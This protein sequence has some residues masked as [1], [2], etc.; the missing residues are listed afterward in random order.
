MVAAG[1]DTW[2]LNRIDPAGLPLALRHELDDL[3]QRAAEDEEEVDTRW[4]YDGAPLR[5]YRAGVN[6]EKGGGVSW[7]YI[8][9]NNSLA[10]L[11]RR[12]PLGRH[13]RPGAARLGMPLA[14]HPAARTGRGRR[15]DPPHVGPSDPL[16]PR[17]A[18]ARTAR[19]Q[20]SQVHLAVDVANAPLALEQASRY[21]SRSRSRAVYEAAKS[22]VEQLM[23]AIHGRRGRGYG[24]ARTGLGRP[25]RGRRRSTTF[26][27]FDDLVP[28]RERD[29]E[30]TPVEERAVTIYGFGKRV[31]GMTF[32]PGGDVSMVLYDKVLQARLS[33]KRHM[34]PIWAAAGW[35]PGVPVTRNEARL[36]RPAVREL[37]L[38]HDLRPCLDDP[39]E[40]LDAPEGRLRRRGRPRRGRARTRSTSRGSAAWCPRSSDSQ[41]VA[42]ADRPRLEGRA[43]G[44]LRRRA[45]RGA[46][47]DPP[48]AARART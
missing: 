16:P 27:P 20:V 48:Q 14:P 1:I 22:E 5:M 40:F 8:L 46:P 44:H 47:P 19:W 28:E 9:R 7:S 35:Q 13:R 6:T 4:V 2:Y 34:E 24:G 11:I 15:A 17:T 31:S 3:Q 10:L 18:S 29:V 38:P 37:G 26:D 36:R 45:R 39:W 42:L 30:P 23:R 12:A 41:P 21:V 32:S 33:G 43:V 25:L